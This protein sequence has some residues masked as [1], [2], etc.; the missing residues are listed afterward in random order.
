MKLE[1]RGPTWQ[2]GSHRI[3][4]Y[5]TN[6]QLS[7]S[8][9]LA[10]LQTSS[11]V[12]G[13]R[14][15]L[16]SDRENN[17]P[18]EISPANQILSSYFWQRSSAVSAMRKSIHMSDKV[19]P[20]TLSVSTCQWAEECKR[21]GKSISLEWYWNTWTHGNGFSTFA[22]RFIWLFN[23]LFW[24]PQETMNTSHNKRSPN[25]IFFE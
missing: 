7:G 1:N 11:K 9:W 12:H 3:Q 20:T 21:G 13:K 2:K 17:G 24:S 4:N 10:D 14:N 19:L 15:D 18:W 6:F 5:F 22:E 23:F 8:Y 25:S 16:I